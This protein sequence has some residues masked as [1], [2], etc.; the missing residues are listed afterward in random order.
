MVSQK[1][2]HDQ[3][4]QRLL[5][6]NKIN[7]MEWVLQ[8]NQI[9]IGKHKLLHFVAGIFIK[10]Q[11]SMIRKKINC[12]RPPTINRLR[13]GL[14]ELWMISNEASIKGGRVNGR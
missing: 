5:M 12:E 4:Y 14:V 11:T 1:R 9:N 3:F 2:V 8:A 13:M 7:S 6:T 10:C